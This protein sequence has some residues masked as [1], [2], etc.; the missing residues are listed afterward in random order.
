MVQFAISL[1]T[2]GTKDHEGSRRL[3]A[4]EFPS[5][6]FVPLVVNDFIGSIV[7][8]RHYP[9]EDA[10]DRFPLCVLISIPHVRSSPIH[11][12]CL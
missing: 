6:T 5:C 1:T 9:Q 11:S 3:L 4:P 8:L 12:R 7:K 10:W 2:K